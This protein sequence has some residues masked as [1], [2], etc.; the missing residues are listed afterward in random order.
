MF[1][2]PR[3]DLLL[4]GTPRG[5]CFAF[6]VDGNA[7]SLEVCEVLL[8]LSLLF[9]VAMPPPS[10]LEV[11]PLKLVIHSPSEVDCWL[12]TRVG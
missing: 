7:P 8:D 9:S 12:R 1:S 10:E 2:F 4:R 5:C 11:P 3:V 6:F